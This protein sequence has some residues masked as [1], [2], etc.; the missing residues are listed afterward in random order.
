MDIPAVDDTV[1]SSILAALENPHSDFEAFFDLLDRLCNERPGLAPSSSLS[2]P[3]IQFRNQEILSSSPILPL[4]A[5]Q[6]LEDYAT[7][8]H[9]LNASREMG[10]FPQQDN[11][12]QLRT[13]KHQRTSPIPLSFQH[14]SSHMLGIT[15]DA[16][17]PESQSSDENQE[18]GHSTPTH[19]PQRRLVQP[20]SGEREARFLDVELHSSQTDSTYSESS[21]ETENSQ[22]TLPESNPYQDQVENATERLVDTLFRTICLSISD[23]TSSKLRTRSFDGS[24]R[25]VISGQLVTTKPDFEIIVRKGGNNIPLIDY[26]VSLQPSVN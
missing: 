26:E 20:L 22:N 5:S 17:I 19:T 2:P 4:N 14:Q 24:L 25:M 10:H 11:Q 8:A 21:Q 6:R 16:T 23:Q 18:L 3:R 1:I 15:N 12:G 7:P 13:V 9:P